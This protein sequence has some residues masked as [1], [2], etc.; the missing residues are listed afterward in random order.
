MNFHLFSYKPPRTT[1][2]KEITTLFVIVYFILLVF[3]SFVFSNFTIIST[4][5]LENTLCDTIAFSN[6]FKFSKDLFVTKGM[7]S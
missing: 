1:Q 5:E 2:K 6:F 3:L 4:I 7:F